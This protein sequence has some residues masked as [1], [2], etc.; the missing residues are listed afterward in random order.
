[1]NDLSR[2]ARKDYQ[3]IINGRAGS[4]FDPGEY[5]DLKQKWF[6][7]Y[8]LQLIESLEGYEERAMERD[9]RD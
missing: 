8:A 9:E 7:K 1:M 4:W 2:Q 6:D 3:E 5:E